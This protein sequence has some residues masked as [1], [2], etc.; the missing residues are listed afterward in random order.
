M[1]APDIAT[2]FIAAFSATDFEGM[3]EVLAPGL[4]AWVTGPDGE[5]EEAM[6]SAGLQPSE[7]TKRLLAGLRY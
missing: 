1:S 6:G 5:M 4:V 2:R 7:E 3:R